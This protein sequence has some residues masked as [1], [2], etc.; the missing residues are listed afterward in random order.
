MCTDVQE[1]QA[2]IFGALAELA[3]TGDLAAALDELY[4]K[5][6]DTPL[7]QSL[8]RYLPYTKKSFVLPKPFVC[9]TVHLMVL[10]HH[11]SAYVVRDYQPSPAA[12]RRSGAERGMT[13]DA[14][15]TQEDSEEDETLGNF[16]RLPRAAA[17]AE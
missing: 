3:R 11:L 8:R 16:T 6:L 10:A 1:D 13:A 9:E 2:V 12:E 4:V 14:R 15:H 5:T 17:T 7:G